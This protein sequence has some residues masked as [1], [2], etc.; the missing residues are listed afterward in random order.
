MRARAQVRHLVRPA[1]AAYGTEEV[2]QHVT[3]WLAARPDFEPRH[4]GPT[5]AQWNALV[6]A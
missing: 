2:D 5:R 3:A 4:D 6:R 1:D